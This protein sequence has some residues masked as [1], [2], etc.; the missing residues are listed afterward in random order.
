I[1]AFALLRRLIP[2]AALH[3]YGADFGV[4]EK[5]QLWAR[6]HRIDDGIVFHGS[7]PHD[8]LLLAL[9]NMH[10]L[11]H[12]S[13]LESCPMSL[14]E[15]MSLGIPA[16]GGNQSGGVPWVLDYGAA[17]VLTDIR[18]P[19]SMCQAMR[20]VLVDP[21]LYVRLAKT[22]I[23]RAQTVFSPAT[24]VAEYEKLYQSILEN[25]GNVALPPF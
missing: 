19:E 23:A 3:V 7:T 9:H 15:A 4:S 22:A 18:S 8:Q 17:G 1:K 20:Q 21:Q 11:L 5:A 12:P 10:L 14:I 24:V 13:L 16:V 6:S 25:S 2:A